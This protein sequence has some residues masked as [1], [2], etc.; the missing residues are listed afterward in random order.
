MR[1]S[2]ANVQQNAGCK[3]PNDQLSYR[4][5]NA[6]QIRLISGGFDFQALISRLRQRGDHLECDESRKTNRKNDAGYA[7][8]QTSQSRR[9][10]RMRFLPLLN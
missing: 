10:N 7:A 6:F 4:E 3:R 8:F 2:E 1:G 9:A 5:P